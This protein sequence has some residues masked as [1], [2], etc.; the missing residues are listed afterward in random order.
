MKKHP[1]WKGAT[2]TNASLV[3][4]L[5]RRKTTLDSVKNKEKEKKKKE[6]ESLTS[7]VVMRG[8]NDPTAD[9]LPPSPPKFTF[10]HQ[11]YETPTRDVTKD[12][13]FEETKE[14]KPLV[15]D[16]SVIRYTRF[17]STASPAK[18]VDRVSEVIHTM[19]GKTAVKDH[20]KVKAQFGPITFVAQVFTDPSSEKN[21]VVDFR[22]KAGSGVEFRNLYQEIRAQLADIVLQPTSTDTSKSTSESTGTETVETSTDVEVSA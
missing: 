12:L 19:S 8:H 10:K 11:I 13:D 4:E 6:K 22:K 21:V 18:I 7:D 14:G 9:D 3:A 1:W 16:P 17:P 15:L 20:F 2:I 5:N